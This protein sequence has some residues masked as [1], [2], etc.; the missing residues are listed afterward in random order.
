MPILKYYSMMDVAPTVSAILHLPV[1]AQAKGQ[2]IP[3]IVA[4]LI[5]AGKIAVLAPDAF[6]LFA[7]NL[8]KSEMPYLRPCMRNGVSSCAP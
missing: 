4:D 6:G 8:W 2:P 5:G 7:W 3:E 1:P